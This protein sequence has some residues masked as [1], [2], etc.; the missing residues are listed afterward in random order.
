MFAA[1]G[2]WTRRTLKL[3]PTDV[4]R[5]NIKMGMSPRLTSAHGRLSDRGFR[6]RACGGD[7]GEPRSPLARPGGAA[8]PLDSPM[9][10]DLTAWHGCEYR[11]WRSASK[12]RISREG[13]AVVIYSGSTDIGQGTDTIFPS[14][15]ATVLGIDTARVSNAAHDTAIVPDSGP[16]VAS[17]TA[18]VVGGVVKQAAENLLET[19]RIEVGDKSGTLSFDEVSMRRALFTRTIYRCRTRVESS[20]YLR[21]LSNVRLVLCH[22]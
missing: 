22:R 18:M 16:T 6:A 4:R 17:R 9:V 5:V 15:A 10:A 14:I 20:T 12:V 21:C 13:Q 3:S 2:T 8:T 19:L 7:A 11:E 1:E